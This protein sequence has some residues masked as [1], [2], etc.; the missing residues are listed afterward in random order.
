MK[1]LLSV[2]N[3]S[4]NPKTT[5]I[6]GGKV[7]QQ[8]FFFFQNFR[9]SGK[10]AKSQLK[11][12]KSK[13][14]AGS[15]NVGEITKKKCDKMIIEVSSRTVARREP[16]ARDP[17]R[18]CWGWPNKLWFRYIYTQRN[19]DKSETTKN[20]LW[21]WSGRGRRTMVWTN[22]WIELR[23]EFSNWKLKGIE[24]RCWGTIP[25]KLNL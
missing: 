11:N 2:D 16:T 8:L 25:L 6:W 24:E 7:E 23:P 12:A 3:I 15:D 17:H 18:K 14:T 9:E 10:K 19:L 1:I 5:E 13:E 22:R 21:E 20:G 4:I